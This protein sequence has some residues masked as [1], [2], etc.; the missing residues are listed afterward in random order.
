MV[1]ARFDQIN[2]ISEGNKFSLYFRF[3]LAFQSFIGLTS[4]FP[5]SLESDESSSSSS[6][7]SNVQRLCTIEDICHMTVRQEQLSSSNAAYPE[8][9]ISRK[10][11]IPV[12]F[13]FRSQLECMSFLGQLTGYYR[14]CEKW[15]FSLCNDIIYPRLKVN[16]SNNVH[17]PVKIGN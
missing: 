14:L 1:G 11:G 8:I 3:T 6:S 7:S 5:F 17:G 12:Y 2:M 4:L 16:T 13:R 9:E 10:N 15:S